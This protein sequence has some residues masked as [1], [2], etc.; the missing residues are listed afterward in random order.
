MLD[1]TRKKDAETEDGAALGRLEIGQRQG[2]LVLPLKKQADEFNY[3]ATG[4]RP[5]P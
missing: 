2:G 3:W 1:Q 5:P 4:I